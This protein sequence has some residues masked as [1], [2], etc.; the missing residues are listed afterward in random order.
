MP[1]RPVFKIGRKFGV[2][3]YKPTVFILGTIIPRTTGY[4]I[5]SEASLYLSPKI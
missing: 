4:N 5:L 2:W 3:F 1:V